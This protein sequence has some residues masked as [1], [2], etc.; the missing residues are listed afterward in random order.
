MG[1][2]ASTTI[3]RSDFGMDAA[4]P[5]ITDAVTISFSGEFLQD[6]PAE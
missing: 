6:E 5:N 1:F 4:I 2:N 3:N